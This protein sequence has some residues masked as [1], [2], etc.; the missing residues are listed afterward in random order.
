MTMVAGFGTKGSSD[1]RKLI[2][3]RRPAFVFATYRAVGPTC[4]DT[5]A[6]LPRKSAEPDQDTGGCYAKQ[7]NCGIHQAKAA[8]LT[9]DCHEWIDTRPRNAIIRFNVTG[10]IVGVDG[11]EYREAVRSGM[12]G[13]PD[14]QAWLYTHAWA[15]PAIQ[16]WRD[17]LPSNCS[18]IASCDSEMEAVQA[19]LAG[20][21]RVAVVG[22]GN[23]NGAWDASTARAYRESIQYLADSFGKKLY[24]C[25]AQREDRSPVGC[26]DCR[27]CMLPD[28]LVGFAAHGVGKNKAIRSMALK[29][30]S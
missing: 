9:F 26:A 27:A 13:R 17:T 16:A 18:V 11:P 21:S 10:D 22:R 25:P 23:E 20:W 7:G 6:L 24:M 12:Q 2:G 5:C 30:A 3:Y 28:I 4:P 14:L 19:Y 15:D 29:I 8:D 1:N